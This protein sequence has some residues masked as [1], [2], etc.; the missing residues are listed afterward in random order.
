MVFVEIGNYL[1]LELIKFIIF[2][3]CYFIS[4]QN[5]FQD[6]FNFDCCFLETI[7]ESFLFAL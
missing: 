5:I 2:N 3:Y 4:V 7:S 6:Y 1:I